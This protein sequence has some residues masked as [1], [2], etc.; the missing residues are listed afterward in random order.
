MKNIIQTLVLF[1]VLVLTSQISAQSQIACTMDARMCPDGSYVGRTGPNCEFTAC[2]TDVTPVPPKTST[3]SNIC[4]SL[5][6]DSPKF[7]QKNS[8]VTNLQK[9]LFAIYNP[10][11]TPTGYFGTLTRSYIL[12]FQKDNGIAQVGLVGP[13]TR[14]ALKRTCD[15]HYSSVHAEQP[16]TSCKVWFDGCNTCYRSTEGGPLACTKMA[17]IWA[18]SGAATCK[19]SF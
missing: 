3:S 6:V 10:S 12:R 1:V 15:M 18:N 11:M 14:A 5:S 8:S 13:A 2:S 17:C 19:E 16:P 9:Y 7:G 4:T